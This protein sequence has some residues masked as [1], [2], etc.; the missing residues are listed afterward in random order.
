[1]QPPRFPHY[2]TLSRPTPSNFA[3]LREEL[4][5]GNDILLYNQLNSIVSHTNRHPASHWKTSYLVDFDNNSIATS[6]TIGHLIIYMSI[7]LE[8]EMSWEQLANLAVIP[9]AAAT[10]NPVLTL[11]V[12]LVPGRFTEGG[13]FLLKHLSMNVITNYCEPIRRCVNG[14]ATSVCSWV[15]LLHNTNIS[16]IE[17]S[18]KCWKMRIFGSFPVFPWELKSI[19]RSGSF[20]VFVV[21]LL[22]DVEGR[23]IGHTIRWMPTWGY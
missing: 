5:S 21:H 23:F 14:T 11:R 8:Y 15:R 4:S 10:V 18:S 7:M 17:H 16:Y 9:G 1:M 20:R 12:R 2:Y 3:N 6:L 22:D 19:F 13:G